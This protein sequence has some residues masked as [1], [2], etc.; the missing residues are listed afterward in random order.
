MTDND[1]TQQLDTL[2][3]ALKVL[4]ERLNAPEPEQSNEEM[5]TLRAEIA[6]LEENHAAAQS[7]LDEAKNLIRAMLDQQTT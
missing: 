6:R 3:K 2:E 7:A 4:G 5:G 1:Y